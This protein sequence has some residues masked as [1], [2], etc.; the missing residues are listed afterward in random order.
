MP[1]HKTR[2]EIYLIQWISF[3]KLIFMFLIFR[4]YAIGL[5]N[6]HSKPLTTY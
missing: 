3:N 1:I 2:R 6:Q 5:R 4:T